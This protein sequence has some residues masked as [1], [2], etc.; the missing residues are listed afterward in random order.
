MSGLFEQLKRRNVFRAAATYAA[1]SWVLLQVID[2]STP[3]LGLPDS[4]MRIATIILL[5]AFIPVLIVSWVYEMTPEGL[6]RD[7]PTAEESP[8]RQHIA[9]KMNTA[10]VV[11]LVLAIVLLAL[12]R[13]FVPEQG[14][15]PATAQST[16]AAADD[17]IDSIAVLPFSDFSAAGDQAYLGDGIADTVLHMLAGVDGLRV[18]ARTS[19]FKF[20][21]ENVDIA[22]IGK[23]LSV[24]SVLEGSVQ[25]AGDQLRII[26]QLVR[27]SDQ[28]HV[29]SQTFDRSRNDIFAIQDE[30]ANAVVAEF[31]GENS[32]AVTPIQSNVT[33][34]EVYAQVLQARHLARQRTAP[35]IDKSIELLAQAINAD[36][37]YAPAHSEMAASL[38]FSSIY[39][40]NEFDDIRPR[41][42]SFVETALNLN[43]NDATA[44][45][46]RHTL[47]EEPEEVDKAMADL[48]RSLELN[49]NNVEVMTWLASYL[50]N[51]GLYEEAVAMRRRAYETDPLNV[52]VRGTYAFLVL[53]VE[54]DADK[55][56]AIAE[57]TV[58]LNLNPA[59]A[60][61]T[62]AELNMVSGRIGGV[63]KAYFASAKYNPES[64]RSYFQM[65]M[66]L[67]FM[68]EN[69]L[70]KKWFDI[71]VELRPPMRFIDHYFFRA[72]HGELDEL[73]AE[74]EQ[75]LVEN[76]Q[77]INLLFKVMEVAGQ[78]GLFDRAVEAGEQILEL[79]SDEVLAKNRMMGLNLTANLAMIYR[80][81]SSSEEADYFQ[82]KF[83][84]LA[85]E[86]MAEED[87][88]SFGKLFGAL[89]MSLVSEDYDKFAATLE[90]MPVARPLLYGHLKY[91]KIWAPAME[92]KN[93]RAWY[94]G[95]EAKIVQARDEIMAIDDPAF[96]NP[97]LLRP[98]ESVPETSP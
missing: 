5:L 45:A 16:E 78:Q 20:R 6:K 34:P 82:N 75:K 79:A 68:E 47:W 59:R 51:A 52:Q 90:Q 72:E 50:G 60:L 30:I 66:W 27:T 21:D 35:E 71:A 76:P 4:L 62:L 63:A 86:R 91:N 69:E 57:E 77:S 26:A 64:P 92:N 17:T 48:E 29:W 9:S 23:Q 95:F 49:P 43:P 53:Q 25:V 40:S 36:P 10:V 33:T 80:R 65:A 2:L 83:L 38:Y 15:I 73:L 87:P 93:V 56:I 46:I 12:D 32:D 44:Y 89:Y 3:I 85:E 55:A 67:S 41:I 84:I 22:T 11:L 98:V 42:Q 37:T 58:A 88:S 28:S 94:D 39:G 24:D 81:M 96:H 61:Q 18:A 19:S 7:T 14:V 13:Y 54:G 97:R 74:T 8:Y 31:V 70:S 1:L